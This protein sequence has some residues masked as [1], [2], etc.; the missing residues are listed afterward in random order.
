MLYKKNRIIYA[1]IVIFTYKKYSSLKK[2]IESIKKNKTYKYHKLYIFSDAPKIKNEIKKIKRVRDYINKIQGFKK[3]KIILRK[4]NFGLALNITS[5]ISEILKNEKL[6]IFLED[7]LIVSRNFLNYMNLNLSKYQK[8][9]KVWHVSGF[10]FNL[11]IN[12]KET[13][14]FT[15]VANCWGWATWSNR[16]KYFKKNP[17]EIL[18]KWSKKKIE[19]FNFDD[20]YNFFS[21][22]QRN[23]N[24]TLN[25]WAIFWYSTIFNKRGLC[26]NPIKSMTKN[27]GIGKS[28]TNTNKI[29]KILNSSVN[30]IDYKIIF[31]KIIKENEKIFKLLKKSFKSLYNKNRL[32]LFFKY[33]N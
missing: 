10:N 7:D 32:K 24:K 6:A 19:E 20:T 25:S 26:I 2:L 11:K 31:P 28:A 29:E 5:G 27:I 12:S 8:N 3:K 30:N 22:I 21:Q 14:F 23:Q 9:K 13:Q 4:K 33:F 15:R 1:P 16:W 17:D 18:N